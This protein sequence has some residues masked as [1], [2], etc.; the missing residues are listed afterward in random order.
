MSGVAYDT[1]IVGYRVGTVNTL[2]LWKSEAPSR[3]TSGRS[4]PATITERWPPRSGPRASARSSTPTTRASWARSSASNSR[5]SSR[6]VHCRTCCGSTSRPVDCP[7]P[8]TT[9]LRSS[10]TTPTPALAVPELMR[11]P[12]LDTE[13]LAWERRGTSPS[14]PSPTPTTPSC[15]RR[16]RNGRVVC[17][18]TCC[19]AAWRSSTRS[20]SGS[21][22]RVRRSRVTQGGADPAVVAH[23]GAGD[24]KKVRMAHLA[25]VGATRSTGCRPC[26]RSCSRRPC[27]GRLPRATAPTASTNKTNGVT[28]RRWLRKANA[29]LSST[30]SSTPSATAGSR[31]WR[32]SRARTLRR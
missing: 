8:S 25:I 30:S 22:R 14:G 4:T 15:P 31:T 5:C 32:N 23:R 28:P 26:T 12:R 18:R 24:E 16:S 17:C 9:A 13:G 21:W 2:R 11:A 29:R 27:S 6:H 7:R 19:R 3:S 1:P 10:S 20:T